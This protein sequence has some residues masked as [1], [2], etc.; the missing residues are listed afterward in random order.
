MTEEEERMRTALFIGHS[1]CH[2]LSEAAVTAAIEAHIQKGVTCFL[3]GGQGAFDRLCARC[4][5]RLKEKY[6]SVRNL[7]VIP[8]LTFGIF[9][10]TLFDEIIYPD[11]FER[12]NFKAAIPA[13]NKYMVQKSAFAICYVFRDWGGAAQTYRLARKAGLVLTNLADDPTEQTKSTLSPR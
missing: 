4:V 13:R 10:R 11:G 6:P 8:Y 5:S 7:L 2:C 12:Y 9:D 1:D 3:S